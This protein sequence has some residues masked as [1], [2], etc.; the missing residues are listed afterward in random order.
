MDLTGGK[1]FIESIFHMKRE[2]D[3]LE[4]LDVLNFNKF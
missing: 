2:F 1:Y 4:I 3:I